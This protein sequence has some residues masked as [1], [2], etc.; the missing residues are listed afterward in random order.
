LEIGYAGQ[1]VNRF[2][3]PDRMN[4]IGSLSFNIRR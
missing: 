1:Y 2:G 3:V 4:H